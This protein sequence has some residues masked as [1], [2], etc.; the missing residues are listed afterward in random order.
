MRNGYIPILKSVVEDPQIKNDPVL[1]GF[2]R[3]LEHA[4]PMPNSPEMGGVWDPAR[5]AAL[6]IMS[7][8]LDAESALE[9]ADQEIKNT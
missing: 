6:D 3:A 7:R 2:A 1:Y 9:K 4:V 5:R 8:K